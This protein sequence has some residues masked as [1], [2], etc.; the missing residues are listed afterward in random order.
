MTLAD[1]WNTIKI[2]P[3]RYIHISYFHLM[4]IHLDIKYIL[5]YFYIFHSFIFNNSNI[6]CIINMFL[7]SIN[8]R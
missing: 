5:R 7:K 2:Y 1:N 6:S 8:Y 4:S 3:L